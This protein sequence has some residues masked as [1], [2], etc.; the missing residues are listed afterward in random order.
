MV[1]G[2]RARRAIASRM[3]RRHCENSESLVYSNLDSPTAIDVTV[4]PLLLMR[5]S[6]SFVSLVMAVCALTFGSAPLLGGLTAAPKPAAQGLSKTLFKDAG[7]GFKFR[8]PNKCTVVPSQQDLE[9]AGLLARMEHEEEDFYVMIFRF[10]DSNKD[11]FGRELEEDDADEE[12]EGETR[13]AAPRLQID[14]V[15]SQILEKTLNDKNASE[16]KK[17]KAN[18]EKGLYRVWGAAGYRVEV[19]SYPGPEADF[20]LVYFLGRVLDRSNKGKKWRSII[21]KSGRSFDR[22]KRMVAPDTSKMN[23]AQLLRYH[24]EKDK[25][26]KDWRVMATPSKQFIV[27]TSSKR[28][29]FIKNVIKHL[30]RSRTLFEKDFPPAQYG[31]KLDAISIVR[32]CGTED[33]FHTYGSTDPGVVGWFNPISEELVLF[34]GEK[35]KRGDMLTMGVMTHEAFHQ[36]CHFLFQRSEA[37]RW[38]DEGLGDYYIDAGWFEGKVYVRPDPKNPLCQLPGAKKLVE[39]G[40]MVPLEEHLNFSHQEWQR[41]GVPSYMQSWAIIYMLRKGTEGKVA[42][43]YWKPEYANIIPN[44]VKTLHSGYQ[45]EYAKILKR[46]ESKA[47]RE[48]RELNASER[49]VGREDISLLKKKKIWKAAMEASW[50]QV[51]IEEFE[52]RWLAYVGEAIE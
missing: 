8:P 42:R 17:I 6:L 19:F 29:A 21:S 46:R 40:D 3:H 30:E 9:E 33:E 45:K 26:F 39:E 37:H 20:H 43:K 52:T 50:G 35:D 12:G 44:Y 31:M 32:I 23:Y 1:A 25:Q 36:Y 22:E 15:L 34:A 41:I 18:G 4:L 16:N 5:F 51:D 48:K 49:K 14:F 10:D 24:K 2:G 13:V 11:A 7:N 38:F 27:K 47:K 28:G